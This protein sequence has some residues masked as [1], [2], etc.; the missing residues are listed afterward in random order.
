MEVCD[1]PCFDCKCTKCSWYHNGKCWYPE[2]KRQK[3]WHEDVRVIRKTEKAVLLEL[4]PEFKQAWFPKSQ[5]ELRGKEVGIPRWLLEEK[6][7]MP[8]G[9]WE[10]L[11]GMTIMAYE[12]RRL[13]KIFI[14]LK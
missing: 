9:E 5:V 6:G 4:P 12:R 7:W 10:E 11:G 1:E 2:F 14:P 3:I 13:S 8:K